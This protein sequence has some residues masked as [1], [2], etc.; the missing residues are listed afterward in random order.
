MKVNMRR[1][2]QLNKIVI[3]LVLFSASYLFAQVNKNKAVEEYN[4]GNYIESAKLFEDY[5]RA[6]PT[7]IVAL[8]YLINSYI[9]L[10]YQKK[11]IDLLELEVKRTPNNNEL[12]TVLG[13]LYFNEALVDNKNKKIKNSL[14]NIKAAEK[15]GVN[16][17]ELFALKAQLLLSL[18]RLSEAEQVAMAGNKLYPK[19][20]MLQK[21]EVFILIQ[22]KKY[23][24]ACKLL[25]PMWKSKKDD[26]QLGL[27]LAMLYRVTNKVKE[28]LQV[29]NSLLETYPKEMAVYDE[30]IELLQLLN[31]QK[32]LRELYES[33][34]LKFPKNKSFDYKI[35]QTYI[36]EKNDSM[37]IVTL[38]KYRSENGNSVKASLELADLYVNQNE[39]SEAVKVLIET[40]DEN[41][42]NQ[43]LFLK[44]GEIYFSN[45]D[46]KNAEKTYLEYLDKFH[47]SYLPYLEMGK[48]YNEINEY[49]RAKNYILDGLVYDKDNPF[50]QYQLAVILENSG[51]SEKCEEAYSAAF[52][53]SINALVIEQ[54]FIKTKIS[55]ASSLIELSNDNEFK[56]SKVTLLQKQT[57][58]SFQYLLNNVTEDRVNEI[59]VP[60]VD[61]YPQSAILLYYQGE[62][63]FKYDKLEEAAQYYYKALE[64]N[65]KYEDAHFRLAEIYLKQKKINQAMLSLKRMLGVNQNSKK[66]YKQLIK[67]YQSNNRL[68]ELCNEWLNIYKSQPDNEILE[69]FLITA[70]HKAGRMED[71]TEI[72]NKSENR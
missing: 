40:K 16:N 10:G 21:T 54:R 37:A 12:K 38:N 47:E 1:V 33:M 63:A 7:D 14:K 62:I 29:Y 20:E 8:Q 50:L 30:V 53:A 45:N 18:K 9:Q 67:V 32:E 3:L 57:A 11:A 56:K 61:K 31:K 25:E 4:K 6:N 52:R 43:S 49:T 35:A 15:Y 58:N 39:K 22:N 71:A 17:P 70:L 24:R 68:D 13:N 46:I 5:N 44:L 41:L 23:K 60:I 26:I 28:S 69:E 36:K 34:K 66:A 59:L 64:T 42:Y 48:L 2:L 27:Q 51:E 72:I 65:S 55:S 19:N